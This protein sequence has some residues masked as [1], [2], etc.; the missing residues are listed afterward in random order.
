MAGADQNDTGAPVPDTYPVQAEKRYYLAFEKGGAEKG[1]SYVFG[2]SE[3][4][5]HEFNGYVFPES[6]T[7]VVHLRD[8]TNDSS[9]GNSG[10]VT[11]T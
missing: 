10:N 8:K 3:T 9:A 5:G 11:V 7:F 1:R 4:G 2:V 6:G